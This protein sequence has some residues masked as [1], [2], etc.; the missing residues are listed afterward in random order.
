MNGTTYSQI[1]I[2]HTLEINILRNQ[3]MQRYSQ[4]IQRILLK[5]YQ[6]YPKNTRMEK[7]EYLKNLEKDLR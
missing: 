3:K 4:I 7:K 1:E 2:R 6:I 5:K